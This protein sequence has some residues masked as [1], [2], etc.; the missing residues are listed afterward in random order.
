MSEIEA[1]KKELFRVR[2]KKRQTEKELEF[3][4][5]FAL[6]DT[7]ISEEQGMWI[8]EIIQSYS[9]GR[10]DSLSLVGKLL[11]AIAWSNYPDQSFE[12]LVLK[13]KE[14]SPE[15][16]A[17]IGEYGISFEMLGKED[18]FKCSNF[19]DNNLID[20][21]HEEWDAD[22]P[23]SKRIWKDSEELFMERIDEAIS[24]FCFD[25]CEEVSKNLAKQDLSLEEIS[26]L[27]G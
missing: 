18:S 6:S 2:D 15:A 20:C 13:V 17:I 27:L 8:I 21:D 5:K 22:I 9:G 25:V 3:W 24:K 19:R 14:F 1:M 12:S 10:Y 16:S 4:K 23:A 26:S 7:A 11:S